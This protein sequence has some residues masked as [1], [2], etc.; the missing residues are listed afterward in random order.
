[1]HMDAKLKAKFKKIL[2]EERQRVLNSVSRPLD[3]IQ[4]STDDLADE[5]DQAVSEIGQNLT[6]TLRDRERELLMSLNSALQRIDD[7]SFGT[8]NSCEE[9]IEAR[10]LEARPI[11]TFCFSCQEEQEHR[12][13]LFA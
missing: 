3:D 13:K 9:P 11:C 2:L 12:K 7:G 6:L 5:T 1:M 8:C 10:R 4:V